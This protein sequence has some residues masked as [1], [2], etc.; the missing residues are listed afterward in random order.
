MGARGSRVTRRR[1][2]TLKF[3]R[4]SVPSRVLR[5]RLTMTRPHIIWR[6]PGCRF[7]KTTLLNPRGRQSSESS[8]AHDEFSQQVVVPCVWMV[9]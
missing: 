5:S 8:G 3:R 7:S 4:N 9:P 6:R 1:R 2:L